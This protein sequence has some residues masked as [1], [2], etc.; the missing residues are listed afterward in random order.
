MLVNSNDNQVCQPNVQ[1]ASKNH[2]QRHKFAQKGNQEK[3]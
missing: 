1:Q 2:L 3:K